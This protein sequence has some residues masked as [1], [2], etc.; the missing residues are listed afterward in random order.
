MLLR[1]A[2]SDPLL[3]SYGIIL[4]DEAHERTLGTDILMGLLKEV[5]DK[6]KD[7]KI[8]IMSATLDAEKFQT[9]FNGAPLMKIPGR[10]YPVELFYT[11][12]PEQDYLDAAITVVILIHTL[13]EAAGD[14]LLFLNGQEEIDDA[15]HRIET[16][17]AGLGPDVGTVTCIP[18]YSSLPPHLQQRI[19]E[20][21]PPNKPN[22]AIGRKVVIATNIAETSITIDGVVFVID[23]GF[24]KQKVFNARTR[25]ES[26]TVTKISKASAKQRAGRAGRTGPGKCFRLY[27]ETSFQ[28]ELLENTHPEILRSNLGTVILNLKKLGVSDIVRFDFIDPPHPENVMR[29]LEMLFYLGAVDTE[30]ALTE[31]GRIMAEFPLDPQ[32]SRML[33]ASAELQCAHQVMSIVAM[34]S[35]P[36]CFVRP[37]DSQAAADAAK[38]KFTRSEGDHLT[39]LM[40]Y[41]EFIASE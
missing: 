14:I 29:A 11:S 33:I 19:F 30:G 12:E 39:L 37:A 40:V 22:G 25:V 34:L 4:L 24:A 27:T 8:V 7:L 13:E 36:P 26:L 16:E 21:A 20:R 17:I 6:R 2:M 23:P 3:R 9:Y 35:V 38:M 41:E 5:I 28:K 10:T 15:C 18:L 32:L 1:E 31:T